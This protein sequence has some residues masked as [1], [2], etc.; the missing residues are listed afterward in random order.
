MSAELRFI[1]IFMDFYNDGYL[2]TVNS[3]KY[4]FKL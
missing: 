3:F 2:V 1:I 4:L